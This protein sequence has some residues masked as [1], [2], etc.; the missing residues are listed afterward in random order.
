MS[1]F[2]PFIVLG[3]ATGSVYALAAMGLVVTYTTSGVLNFAHGAVGMVVAYVFYDLRQDMPTA[4]ALV[5][6]LGVVAPTVGLGLDRLFRRLAGG[7]AANYLV[8]SIGLL[9]ALQSAVIL[10]YGAEIQTVEPLFS[11]SALF[12]MGSVRVGTDQAAMFVI[13]LALALALRL[14]FTRTHVGLA[15]RAVVDD[16]ELTG[17]T[18]TDRRRVTALA[19]MIGSSCAGLSGIL[20]TP[21]LGLD[22]VLL[23]LLV[24]QALA[25]AVAGGLR[26]LPLTYL[27]G[28]GVGVS[29][30]V[31]TKLVA[32]ST[33]L[34]GLPSAL[35]FILLFAI[36]VFLRPQRF[37]EVRDE[38]RS[39]RLGAGADEARFPWP[40]LA[41]ATAAALI[42]GPRL[43][44]A[45]LT[46]VTS[47]V[48]F[49]LVFSSLGLLV[50]QSRLISLCHATFA[51]FGA[52][53][54]SHLHD[55]GLPWPVA[56][57]LS[58]L[59]VAP[60]GALLAVPALRLPP[61]FL[62]IATF[63]FGLLAERLLYQSS[64]MFGGGRLEVPRPSAFTTDGEF[65]YVVLAVVVVAVAA[66]EWLRSSR[67]GLLQ[68]ALADSPT[69]F[70]S[71]GIG[72][73]MSRVL[74]FAVTSFFAG[75]AG[76]LLGGVSQSVG[77]TTFTFSNSLLWVA[78]LVVA[79]P[80]SLA[81]AI[82]AAVA[83]N[84]VPAMTTSASVTDWMALGFGVSA[85]LFARSA[86]GVA[87]VFRR[88]W[89]TLADR[90][91]GRLARSPH[92]DRR[93]AVLRARR[94]DPLS[95]T[96]VQEVLT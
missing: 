29:A 39:L 82:L 44:D 24:L 61:M 87:G 56:L 62:A 83:L 55:A 47:T 21:L 7:T 92:A 86:D 57:V 22:A 43:D 59:A 38:R 95:E 75:V 93:A 36:L 79:G 52:A 19:W 60:I 65:F 17:L 77:Q 42:V 66:I 12:T 40:T 13:A 28:L 69:A 67:L 90:S 15:T 10:H 74:V 54:L 48:A 16:P 3:L 89:A 14:F 64:V 27:G 30:A 73:V 41:L 37:V 25:A 2:L 23:T 46:N 94:P 58:G 6:C 70:V 81:G 84:Q 26:S 18:G 4:L 96:R 68:R 76:G 9:V 35:P 5:L 72:S 80:T 50:G 34:T 49:V 88:D 91:R 11:R 51:I 63:G 78:V 45:D 71:L 85:V 53:A 1:D 33:G 31:A 32:H 20:V 8:A